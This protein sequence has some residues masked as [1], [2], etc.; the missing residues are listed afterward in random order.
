MQRFKL[1]L[2]KYRL[3]ALLWLNVLASLTFVGLMLVV[4]LEIAGRIE[5]GEKVLQDALAAMNRVV[6]EGAS[7]STRSP[8]L[9]ESAWGAKS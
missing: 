9:S 5:A 2:S 1:N 3:G 6:W 8:Q 4:P 7:D